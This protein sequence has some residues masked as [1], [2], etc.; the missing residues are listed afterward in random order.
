MTA[1][2]TWWD[3]TCSTSRKLACRK[4]STDCTTAGCPADLWKLSIAARSWGVSRSGL[5][6]CPAGDAFKAPRNA[7]E[8][9][10][11]RAVAAG[12]RVWLN[13][14]DQGREGAWSSWG[15]N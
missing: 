13:Y 1:N 9:T 4:A 6:E 2:G 7:A 10:S 3:D 11:P 14:A 12:Q 15:P 8:N 5:L